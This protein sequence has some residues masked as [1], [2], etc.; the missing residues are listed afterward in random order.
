MT[1]WLESTIL[2]GV[3]CYA[4]LTLPALTPGLILNAFVAR[5]FVAST[6]R[7]PEKTNGITDENIPSVIIIDEHNSVST[8]VGIYRRPQSVGETVGIYRQKIF[9]RYIP[10]VSP[11]GY[12]VCLEICN[13]VVTSDDFTDGMIEGFKLR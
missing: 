2:L 11:T 8:S 3:R 6:T 5:E 13:G 7:K 10:T 12:T 4:G 1:V 9:H